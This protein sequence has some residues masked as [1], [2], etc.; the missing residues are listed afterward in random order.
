MS[1]NEQILNLSSDIMNLQ[2]PL[3]PNIGKDLEAWMEAENMLQ[4]MRKKLK[5]MAAGLSN[6][7]NVMYGVMEIMGMFQ[8]IEGDK[9]RGLSAID[10]LDSD[11]RSAVSGA[12][13]G[14]V[15]SKTGYN[16][17]GVGTK[18]A[19]QLIDMIKEIKTF[20]KYEKSQGAQGKKTA[21]DGS[22]LKNLSSAITQLEEPYGSAW[23]NAS[24]MAGK[25]YTWVHK[26]KN[27]KYSPELK[28]IQDGLQTLNQSTSALSTSTNTQLDFVTK[29]FQQF[30][31]ID[32]SAIQA[33]QKLNA[34][35]IHNQIK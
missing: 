3:N 23:G 10:N 17:N 31:G 34:A 25:A 15:G 11:L 1:G 30:L 27:G 13:T 29:E 33:Y 19:Q 18:M 2:K 12:Q 32:E 22:M 9:V 5:A 4:Q 28:T 21:V 6:M 24:K 20:I 7:S 16:G 26:A 35:M 8:N 14:F